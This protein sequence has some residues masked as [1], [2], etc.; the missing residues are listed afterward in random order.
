M[1]QI[2]S[3]LSQNIG[4][5]ETIYMH[6]DKSA[7]RKSESLLNL[8]SDDAYCNFVSGIMLQK[9]INSVL[10][11]KIH[12]SQGMRCCGMYRRKF[13]DSAC[14]SCIEALPV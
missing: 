12:G 10:H 11:G 13:P 1:P 7:A 4:I 6:S 2:G 9:D 3:C 5:R 14:R 8:R